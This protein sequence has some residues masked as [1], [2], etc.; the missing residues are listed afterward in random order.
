MLLIYVTVSKMKKRVCISSSQVYRYVNGMKI[1]SDSILIH[2]SSTLVAIVIR[3]R[4][5]TDDKKI[6]WYEN[7]HIPHSVVIN[8]WTQEQIENKK[9]QIR[10]SSKHT[11]LDQV[12]VIKRSDIDKRVMR[13]YRFVQPLI[14]FPV[15]SVPLNHITLE[16]G[17][18][19]EMLET[20]I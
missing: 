17:S 1:P 5:P 6:E 13:A 19:M 3:K 4:R 16:C 9:Q 18:E 10:S 20:R 15:Q 14:Q 11:K 8:D 2:P 7:G 12:Y